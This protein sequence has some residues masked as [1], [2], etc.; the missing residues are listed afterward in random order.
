MWPNGNAE[1]SPSSIVVMHLPWLQRRTRRTTWPFS[2]VETEETDSAPRSGD[3]MAL[4]MLERLPGAN[5][6]KRSLK[7]LP[8]PTN[9]LPAPSPPPEMLNT[10]S[11]EL[12]DEM[13]LAISWT[14]VLFITLSKMLLRGGKPEPSITFFK[15]FAMFLATTLTAEP[16]VSAAE[17]M[18]ASMV[19]SAGNT[20]SADS[21]APYATSSGSAS[22]SS[23]DSRA[24]SVS[25]SS[26]ASS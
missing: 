12:P 6:L 25:S 21:S 19:S 17:A 10:T 23:S 15:S 2:T 20:S 5:L 13:L 11:V 8:K 16:T 3:P 14:K 1:S 18:A 22:S 24:A 9:A 26:Y 4:L 7:A